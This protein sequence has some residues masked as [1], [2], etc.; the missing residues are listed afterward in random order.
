[1]ENI[2]TK[3]IINYFTIGGLLAGLLYALIAIIVDILVEDTTFSFLQLFRQHQQSWVLWLIYPLPV[4][5]AFAGNA[6]GKNIAR[7]SNEI[8]QLLYDAEAKSGRI[9]RFVEQL[10]S[11]DVE[12][13][14]DQAGAEDHLSQSL[15]NLR[16][17]LRKNHDEEE[18]RKREDAQRNWVTEGIA[19]FSEILR[20]Y[21]DNLEKLSQQVTSNLAHYISA[22]QVGFFILYEDEYSEEKHFELTAHFAYERQKFAEKTLEFGEGLIGA[23][24]MEKETIHLKEASENY[25][26]ITSGLGKANPRSILIVPLKINEEVHGV[27]EIAS[28]KHYENHEVEFVEKLGESIAS[29]IASVKINMRTNRLLKESQAQAEKMAQQEEIMRQN[30]EKL[31][32]TQRQAAKQSEEFISFTNSV[33]HTMIRAEYDTNGKL[34]YANTKFLEKLEYTNASEVEG[35]SIYLFINEKDKTWFSKIWNTLAKGGK[36][37]EGDM[38]HVTKFGNDLWTMATYVCQRNPD[39]SVRKILFL[40]IDITE[41]KK[42]NLDFKGQID[43]LNRSMIKAEYAPDG[44]II[45]A[46]EK[47]LETLHYQ[48]EDVQHK[49]VFNFVAETELSDFRVI[50]NNVNNRIPFEGHQK[51]RTKDNQEIWLHANYT[52]VDD[53]YG[54]IAKIIFIAYNIT[55][56]KHM[57]LKTKKQAEQL[58]LQE[59]QLQE[60]QEELHQKLQATRQ[61]VRDQFK[62]IETVKMLNERTLEGTLDAII[63]IDKKGL[64]Q[65]FNKAAEELFNAERK[66]V[67]G[68]PIEGLL[69]VEFQEEEDYLGNYLNIKKAPA[70][71]KRIE[72]FFYNDNR[73]KVP[74]LV[75]LSQAEVG[76]EYNL[77]A[78]IQLIE[79]E[80][81]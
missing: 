67:L 8:N 71:N 7:R 70:L 49:K 55:D 48:K 76:K 15:I 61:E 16:D 32:A 11:G 1:M 22:E 40:G 38:K 72:V 69:P 44:K 53:M 62:E 42:L 27:I 51:Y 29:T 4:V 41:N 39:G 59:K 43:A 30:M 9:S 65:F 78:F 28:F 6:I 36:H 24:A 54:D 33:N 5:L 13:T 50:W 23:A 64:V 60:A 80:L 3:R 25:V 18:Q 73:E 52:V 37:F 56:Q 14:F 31:K 2:N 26:N 35:Q 57:E 47:F 34:L 45:D 21:N 81:F 75:T 10:R 12:A 46:N 66:N 63:T 79:V 68:K 20:T 17:Q 74:V 77:T 19:K 58:M